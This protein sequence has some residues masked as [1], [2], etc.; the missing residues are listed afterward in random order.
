MENK[1][2]ANLH[3]KIRNKHGKPKTKIGRRNKETPKA[4]C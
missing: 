4:N 3:T 1:I 2:I